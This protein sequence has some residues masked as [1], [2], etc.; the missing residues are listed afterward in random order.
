MPQF[1]LLHHVCDFSTHV[2]TSLHY[3]RPYEPVAFTKLVAVR[4]P[5]NFYFVFLIVLLL[6]MISVLRD[7]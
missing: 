4:K 3:T 1:L 6:L 2:T 5:S 7:D